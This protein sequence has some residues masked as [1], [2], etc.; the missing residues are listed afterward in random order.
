M[1]LARLC[2]VVA[3]TLMV[4]PWYWKEDLVGES[5][6]RIK[7]RSAL[8][9]STRFPPT[10]SSQLQRQVNHNHKLANF[11]SENRSDSLTLC[12]I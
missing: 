1:L 11:V 3:V 8:S 6:P 12:T 10:P 5:H 9:S 4:K 2:F 7:W